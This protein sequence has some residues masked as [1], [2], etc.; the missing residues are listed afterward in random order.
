LLPVPTI[1]NIP[2][3]SL[4]AVKMAQAFN[5][6]KSIA[7]SLQPSSDA[8]TP[9]T[10]FQLQPEWLDLFL[11]YS[12]KGEE[13]YSAVK[14]AAICHLM[15]HVLVGVAFVLG[16]ILYFR[17]LHKQL[18]RGSSYGSFTGSTSLG[19]RHGDYRLHTL[20]GNYHAMAFECAAIFISAV[21]YIATCSWV[22][23][24][25]ALIYDLIIIVP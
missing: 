5:I 21:T 9:E 22:S 6:W 13:V 18:A 4:A 8:W 3:F 16:A 25:V 24:L 23:E 14:T 15:G 7:A 1:I 19:S 2:S 17:V 12:A 10:P 20:R 11:S